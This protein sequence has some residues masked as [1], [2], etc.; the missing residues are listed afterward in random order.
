[1]PVQGT[2]FVLPSL[3]APGVGLSRASAQADALSSVPALVGR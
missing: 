3:L 2:V 1:M